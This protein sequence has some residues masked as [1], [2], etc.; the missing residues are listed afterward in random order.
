[1]QGGYATALRKVSK[2]T[3]KEYMP[4]VGTECEFSNKGLQ[5]WREAKI[6]AIHA[7]YAWIETT[8]GKGIGTY[9]ISNLDFRPLKTQQEIE[10]EEAVERMAIIGG[11]GQSIFTVTSIC[12]QIYDA[13]YHNSPKLGDEVDALETI[14][15][16]LAGSLDFQLHVRF[17]NLNYKIYP[18]G[19]V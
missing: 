1:M 15:T 18:R 16:F 11:K 5:N 6:L 8:I 12:E 14:P 3:T 13:G 19:D 9:Q 7:G 2:M 10:R 4:E 17:L